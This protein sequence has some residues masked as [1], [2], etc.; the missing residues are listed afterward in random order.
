[1]IQKKPFLPFR[2]HLSNDLP[3]HYNYTGFLIACTEKIASPCLRTTSQHFCSP[4]TVHH[5]QLCPTKVSRP[6][7]RS[8]VTLQ[9][10]RVLPQS[11]KTDYSRERWPDF[12]VGP[13]VLPSK[14]RTAP[15]LFCK[16]IWK[17]C[18]TQSHREVRIS[19]R[20]WGTASLHQQQVHT[21]EADPTGGTSQEIMGYMGKLSFSHFEAIVHLKYII[22]QRIFFL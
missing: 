3:Q 14:P 4:F 1:M 17:E 7:L 12:A 10:L 5:A 22:L 13:L 19:Q 11:I 15:G 20:H 16:A 2:F 21:F 6:A 8:P 18:G 9:F